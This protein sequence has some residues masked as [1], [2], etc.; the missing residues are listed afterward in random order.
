MYGFAYIVERI[1]KIYK[2]NAMDQEGTTI[3]RD[4]KVDSEHNIKYYTRRSFLSDLYVIYHSE[5][6]LK[7][8]ILQRTDKAAQYFQECLSGTNLAD[9]IMDEYGSTLTDI[10]RMCYEDLMIVDDCFINITPNN[11]R[12]LEPELME[13]NLDKNNHQIGD[14]YKYGYYD[15]I[16]FMTQEDVVHFSRFSPSKTYG[17]PPVL[18]LYEKILNVIAD[19]RSQNVIP[20]HEKKLTD[21]DYVEY[22]AVLER[23]YSCDQDIEK[24][25]VINMAREMTKYLTI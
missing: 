15:N 23:M 7:T 14:K 13:F 16:V 4:I 20:P 12:R 18:T 22:K 5:S 10:F 19:D 2:E 6:V 1:E 8:N 3:A 9:K 21:N 24:E 11:Y 17:Y 25:F